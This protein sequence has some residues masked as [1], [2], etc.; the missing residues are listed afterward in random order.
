MSKFQNGEAKGESVTDNHF[1]LRGAIDHARYLGKEVFITSMT[2]KNVLTVFGF[3]DCINSLLDNGIQDDSLYFIYLLGRKAHI[4]INTSLGRTDPFVLKNLVKQGTVLGPVL[5]PVINN[6]SLDRIPKEGSGYQ[7]GLANI[8][9]LESVDDIAD[10][11]QNFS[12]LSHSN[13]LI[14]NIQHEKRL[15]FSSKKCELNV[16][17]IKIE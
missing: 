17:R 6:C 7:M 15:N 3:Q 2:L 10:V 8:K 9:S 11:N 5:G 1:I 13:K 16:S 12:S 4:T 14:E